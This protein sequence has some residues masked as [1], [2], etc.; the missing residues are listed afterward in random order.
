MGNP[1][2]A[3]LLVFVAVVLLVELAYVAVRAI[4]QGESQRVR[5]RL[6]RFV[7][8][9]RAE[10]APDIRRQRLYSELPWLHA[11]LRQLGRIRQVTLLIEQAN[12]PYTIGFYLLLAALLGALGTLLALSLALG[13][14]LGIALSL[15]GAALP[16]LWLLYRK[17]ARMQK[18]QRQF[19]E[20]LELLARAMRAGHSFS[21]AMKMVADE[22]E[23]PVGSEF[24]RTIEEINFGIS[25]SE[26]LRKLVERIDS[27]DLKYFV[28][29]VVIQRETGGN[30]AEIV[31]K[32]GTLIRQRF[33]LMGKIRALSAEGRASALVLALLPMLLA[34]YFLLVQREYIMTLVADPI[35]HVMIAGALAM[36]TFGILVMHR[37]IQIKV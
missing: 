37:M 4:R 6:Q 21:S 7:E 34:L 12:A 33:V 2:V 18:F 26:A 31:E 11:A 17:Q 3:G 15:L 16:F 22:F 20:A 23:D 5:R 28:V 24:A 13:I 36:M 1:L 19:P 14:A 27:E 10:Q 25:T 35:G 8:H 32:I 9:H 30:L 29:A